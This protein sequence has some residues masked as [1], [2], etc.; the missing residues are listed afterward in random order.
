VACSTANFTFTFTL[1]VLEV[2]NFA[3]SLALRALG[4]VRIIPKNDFLFLN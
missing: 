1:I 2:G 4:D 3:F